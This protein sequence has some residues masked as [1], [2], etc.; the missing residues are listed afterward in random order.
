MTLVAEELQAAWQARWPEALGLWN[1]FVRLSEPRWCRSTEEAEHEGLNSSFAMIRLADH[2]VVIDLKGVIERGLEGFP[3]EVMAHEIGHHVYCPGD[4]SDQARMIARIRPGL[5]T[6]EHRAP[7]VANLYADLLINDRLQRSAELDM[8]GVYRTLGKGATTPLWTLYM[9]IYEILWGLER[10]SLAGGPISEAMEDDARLGARLVRVYARDWLRGAGSFAVLCLP[11]LLEDAD[12]AALVLL[13]SW[14]DTE[15]CGAGAELTGV[16][17][18]DPDEQQAPRHPSEDPNVSPGAARSTGAAHE[19]RSPSAPRYRDPQELADLY[20]ALGATLEPR[21]I[22]QRYYRERARPYLVRFPEIEGAPATEPYPEGL[23]SWEIGDPGEQLDVLESLVRAPRLIPGLTT[24]QR[25]EGESP[26]PEPARV[27]LDLYVGIDCSGS[28]PDCARALSYPVL[29]GT[30]IALS[31]LRAGGR[32]MAC[33]SGEPGQAIATDGFVRSEKAV[34]ELLTGHLGTGTTFG[35]HR[36]EAMLERRGRAPRPAH[37]L[38]LSDADIF[39]GLESNP[40]EAEGWRRGWAIARRALGE[41]RGGGT[42]VL[43]LPKGY[44]DKEVAEIRGM[45]FAVDTITAWEEVV[46]FAQAFSRR[47]FGQPARR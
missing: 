22:A 3:L 5:P 23:A 25:L 26:G 12:E 46:A 1:R 16:I 27:P 10:Q 21:E 19:P 8:A 41:V 40:R 18:V 44:G 39:Q 33:L 30:I 20:Q 34:M 11:Y 14:L 47:H 15:E 31:A 4:L 38:I 6:L 42:F 24:L 45:G 35:L 28:M 37:L 2:A 29:A 13:G 36:L 7:L 32:V 9:R 43:N 17:V